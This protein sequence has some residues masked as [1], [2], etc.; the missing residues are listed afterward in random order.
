MV[1][2]SFVAFGDWGKPTPIR[3]RILALLSNDVIAR[4]DG[5]FVLGDNF[6]DR[7]VVSVDDPLWKT[8]FLDMYQ[9]LRIPWYPVLGNHDYLTNPQAQIDFSRY[10]PGWCFKNRFY[11]YRF[12]WGPYPEDSVHL[13]A[14]DTVTL[15]PETSR[16][17]MDPYGV[18]LT[19]D[20]NDGQLQWLE[21]VLRTSRSRFKCVMGHYPVFSAGRTH[22]DTEELKRDLLPLFQRYHVDVYLSGHDHCLDY[23]KVGCTHYIVS[24]TGCMLS[25]SNNPHLSGKIGVCYLTVSSS[26][27][28]IQ[29]I[30]MD[31]ETTQDPGILLD[32]SIT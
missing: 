31:A 7:G 20:T 1:Q 2:I 9:R 12:Y 16:K 8:V 29:L 28:R 17:N 22:G 30:G 18:P 27:C 13:I 15:A 24:G 21:T 23:Q 19:V 26:Q 25:G 32:V 5:V 14:I 4:P 10:C 6:Y 3:D 11:D